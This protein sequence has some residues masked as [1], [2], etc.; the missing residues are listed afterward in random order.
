MNAGA[1][2]GCNVTEGCDMKEDAA[3][4][5]ESEFGMGRFKQ[6]KVFDEGAVMLSVVDADAFNCLD[7]AIGFVKKLDGSR[8]PFVLY[9]VEV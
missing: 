6:E 9:V 8:E 5:Q 4:V 1:V 3:L 2:D 7:G